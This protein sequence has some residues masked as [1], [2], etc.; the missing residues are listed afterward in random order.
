MAATRSS[1]AYA[2]NIMTIIV[3]LAPKSGASPYNA[4][5]FSVRLAHHGAVLACS[6]GALYQ[7]AQAHKGAHRA[8]AAALV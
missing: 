8:A 7:P 6:E 4:I 1:L 3:W 5:N 2:R